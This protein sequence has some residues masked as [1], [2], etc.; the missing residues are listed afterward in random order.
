MQPKR[1]IRFHAAPFQSAKLDWDNL[2]V[3]MIPVYI[4]EE[5]NRE[6]LKKLSKKILEC[7]DLDPRK[8]RS[9]KRKECEE[10]KFEE[11][12]PFKL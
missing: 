7:I 3:E 9:F 11:E 4:S 1:K 6:S 10:L 2:K 8:R 5:E 12:N